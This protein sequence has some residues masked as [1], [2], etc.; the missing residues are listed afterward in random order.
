MALA[1][2]WGEAYR[3]LIA[4]V[5]G[6]RVLLIVVIVL[7]A[8]GVLVPQLALLRADA[9]AV[10]YQRSGAATLIVTAEGRIDGLRCE[11]FQQLEN[12]TA[13]GALR[14]REGLTLALLPSTTVRYFES[15]PQFAGVL[16][17]SGTGAGL[18]LSD[19]VADAVGWR[20]GETLSLAERGRVPVAGRFAYPDDG[21]VA[22]L[23]YAIVGDAPASSGLFD[24]CWVTVWPQT[25][26][27]ESLA[28]LVVVPGGAGAAAGPTLLQANATLGARF[29]ADTERVIW[30]GA[31]IAAALLIA[32]A[33]AF[34]VRGRRLELASA[35]HVGVRPADQYAI[36]VIEVTVLA[37]IAMVIV[38]PVAV[39]LIVS[40]PSIAVPLMWHAV[41]SAVL[42]LAGAIGGAWVGLAGLRERH[43]F[44]YFRER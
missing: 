7:T 3:N 25:P 22:G 21:R 28:G 26:I 12:V 43:L 11:A 42:A 41:Q 34:H 16:G 17:A 9:R 18:L 31:G 27:V 24:E 39:S 6:S 32:A 44:R 40:A 35:R 38:L 8:C 4:G 13:A 5:G 23:G 29:S 10:A 15:T 30:S 14:E 19:E 2:V 33:V 1:S 36:T 37:G 20:D